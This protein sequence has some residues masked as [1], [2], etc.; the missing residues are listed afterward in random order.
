ML[1][2]VKTKTPTPILSVPSVFATLEDVTDS[3]FVYKVSYSVNATE[4]VKNNTYVV[5]INIDKNLGN[6]SVKPSLIKN[7]S[8]K[9][10]ISN[11]RLQAPILKAAALSKPPYVL[12][13]TS[14]ITSKIP[15]SSA[16][17]LTAAAAGI[18]ITPGSL[19][20]A[21]TSLVLR[22]ASQISLSGLKSP[23]M[24]LNLG[25]GKLNPSVTINPQLSKA[26][27]MQLLHSGI[28]PANLT[29]ASNT[30]VPTSKTYAGTIPLPTFSQA[31]IIKN[32]PIAKN[33]VASRLSN[34]K[35][36]A[37]SALP[38]QQSVVTVVKSNTNTVTIS[39]TIY[40]PIEQIGKN[41]FNVIF[42][43]VNQNKTIYQTAK[44]LVEHGINLTKLIPTEPPSVKQLS[45]G[46][47]GRALFEVKQLDPYAKGFFVYRRELNPNVPIK[48]A[49]YTQ[50]SKQTLLPGETILYEDR[51][52][53]SNKVLYRFIPFADE[54]L[55]SSIFTSLVVSFKS[56]NI[57]NKKNLNRRPVYA[58]I[59]AKTDPENDYISINVSDYTDS[60]IS[61]R[62]KRRN[63]SKHESTST[64][65]SVSALTHSTA[66]GTRF[67]DNNVKP[68]SIYEYTVDLVFK[69]GYIAAVPTN[70]IVEHTPITNNIAVTKITNINMT[71]YEGLA[72]VTFDIEYSLSE[73]NFELIKKLFSEQKL[74]LEH[75]TE[76]IQNKSKLTT[77]LAYKVI[78]TNLTSG[79]V[80]NFGIISDKKFSD[81]KFGLSRSVKNLESSSEYIYTVITYVRNPET[82]LPKYER[83]V[84]TTS[85]GVPS[86]YSFR[87]YKWYQPITLSEGS[88]VSPRSLQSNHSKSELEQGA[89]VDIRQVP[90]SVSNILPAI[91]SAMATKIKKDTVYLEWKVSGELEKID[92]FVII[93]SIMGMKTV[94]GT[95]H[96]ISTNKSFAF[97]DPLTNGEKGQ[98]EY[99]IIPIYY[100]Y[101]QGKA[102]NTNTVIV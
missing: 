2:T 37:V 33:I 82:V 27:S 80:E 14:D 101:E 38:P 50:V 62:L 63:L 97:V 74:T 7:V 5:K 98:L 87:P 17:R 64:I 18:T 25:A 73:T 15:N 84:A 60:A 32:N 99:S 54:E 4:A 26:Q 66:V 51:I 35:S 53:T 89:V 92:H 79:E 93:L 65:I 41:N 42:D 16:T 55:P 3:F 94:I 45:N 90:I 68:G 70:S 58:V 71:S 75:Q 88:I 10:M 29:K 21:T 19:S 86:S 1:L 102:F 91:D 24:D 77:L 13:Y 23:I 28:D 36:V 44:V 100:D 85:D 31:L 39:E 8:N 12:T 48:N 69:E 67:I 57:A 72:D 40:I 20:R 95:A 11:I 96:A 56:S 22:T 49:R 78:R 47:I 46:V 43:L 83:S 61:M 59:N 81:R 9:Q 76:I 34:I 30:I 52:S 6:Q